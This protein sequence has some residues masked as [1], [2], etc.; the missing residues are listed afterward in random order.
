V[1]VRKSIGS[2]QNRKFL[3]ANPKL[4]GVTETVTHVFLYRLR[5]RRRIAWAPNR[6][7]L[8]FT[9]DAM[10]TKMMQNTNCSIPKLIVHLPVLLTTCLISFAAQADDPSASMLMQGFPPRHVVSKENWRTTPFNRWAFQNIEQ[11]AP[12][13]TI[14]R[15]SQSLTELPQASEK[16]RDAYAQLDMRNGLTVEQY[17]E[18]NMVD[19]L[20]VLKNGR[21]VAEHYHNGQTKDTRHIMFSVGKSFTGIMAETL[22]FEGTLD[23]TKLVPHYVPELAKSGYADATVRQVMDMLVDLEFSEDYADPY[24][25]ISQFIYAAGLGKAPAGVNVYPS[26]YSYLPSLKKEG[27]HGKKWEYVSATTET[28]GWIM[29]RATN[30]S[31]VSLF[32]ERIYKHIHPR[33]DATIIVDALGKEVAAGGMSMTLRDVGRF[34][35]LVAN[36]G[37]YEENQVLPRDVI[38]TIKAG[39]DPEKFESPLPGVVLSY[40]SQWYHDA[41]TGILAG[42]GIHGQAIEIGLENE[43][44]IV[45]QS[46]WP[47]AGAPQNWMRRT[48]YQKAVFEA[49][50]D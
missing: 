16:E 31:W 40:K 45:T 24:S 17:I 49:I 35:Y 43:I 20:L 27:K 21:I 4:S 1:T 30:Q 33:R 19:G 44:I 7:M 28:L 39:G 36:D 13:A 15:G 26:L 34:A 41:T 37:R 5:L 23:D 18:Q 50:G 47:T 25:D 6:T 29:N 46:S 10:E 12:T 38:K 11:I 42:Y 9:I 2:Q 8:G 14:H 48:A 3:L 22:V 32:E